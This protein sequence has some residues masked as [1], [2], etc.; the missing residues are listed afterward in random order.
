[1]KDLTEIKS[2]YRL[3]IIKESPDG[4]SARFNHPALKKPINIIASWGGG[5][6]HVSASYAT[7][8][9]TWEEMCMIKEIFWDDSEVVMQLHPE[10]VEYVNLHPYCL[11]LWKPMDQKIPTPPSFMVGVKKGQTMS[12]LMEEADR[13]LKEYEERQLQR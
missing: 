7:R 6:E 4:F 12:D 13:Y 3:T 10:K 2:N 11:H 9:P 8:C 5:W 1:M